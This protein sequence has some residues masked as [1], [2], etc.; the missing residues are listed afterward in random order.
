MFPQGVLGMTSLDAS[1]ITAPASVRADAMEAQVEF[2][3]T[4]DP[5]SETTGYGPGV[6][7]MDDV[8]HPTASTS[9]VAYPGRAHS[10]DRTGGE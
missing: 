8:A 10:T 5:S 4:M 6:H 2:L 1:L 3:K 7:Q 9:T